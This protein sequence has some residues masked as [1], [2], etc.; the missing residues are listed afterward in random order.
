[1]VL[2]LTALFI[3]WVLYRSLIKRDLHQHKSTLAVGT[4]F[5]GVW[6]LLYYWL[7]A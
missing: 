7:W 3:G 4:L 2:G 6:G 5:I 1:M